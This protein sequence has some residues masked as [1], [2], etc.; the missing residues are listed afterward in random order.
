MEETF[1]VVVL[2]RIAETLKGITPDNGYYSDFSD[3]ETNERVRIGVDIVSVNDTMPC[4]SIIEPVEE[5]GDQ[6]DSP[7]DQPVN[8]YQWDLLISGVTLYDWDNPKN[9]MSSAY[10]ALYDVKKIL[11]KEK[12]NTTNTLSHQPNPFGLGVKGESSQGL[13]ENINFNQ[14]IVRPPEQPSDH[15]FFFLRLSLNII[16]I[17]SE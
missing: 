6:I 9:S 2:E 13:I 17:L 12:R 4:I 10:R 7:C 16:E 14:G 15:T 8:K 1:K 3:T 5:F 11:M